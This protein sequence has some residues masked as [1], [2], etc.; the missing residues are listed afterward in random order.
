MNINVKIETTPDKRRLAVATFE[1]QSIRADAPTL[2]ATFELYWPED[3]TLEGDPY[4]LWFLASA[5]IDT[6]EPVQLTA[7]ERSSIMEAVVV[8]AAS[9][10][11]DW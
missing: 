5:R 8:R 11:S 1:R 4:V 10:S 6:L 7:T 9:L 2:Q 3:F